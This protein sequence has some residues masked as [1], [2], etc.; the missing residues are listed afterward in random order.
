MMQSSARSVMIWQTRSG[1]IS[2]RMAKAPACSS[3]LASSTIFL[4]ERAPLPCTLKPPSALDALR[5]QPQVAMAGM[6]AVTMPAMRSAMS[7][8]PSSL[9][10]SQ[11]ASAMK[12]PALRMALSTDGW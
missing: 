1:T 7:A 11:P 8:P 9:M 5:R 10:A 2:S 3:A 12:R 6:P 4:A